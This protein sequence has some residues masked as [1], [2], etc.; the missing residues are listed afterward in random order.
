MPRFGRLVRVE[1]ERRGLERAGTVRAMGDGGNW[2]DP[3]ADRERLY[4]R[5][6]VDHYHAVEHL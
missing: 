1:A 6:I 3:P 5:R 2:I 4:D